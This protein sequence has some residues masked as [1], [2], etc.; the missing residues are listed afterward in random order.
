[1]W[2]TH[3]WFVGKEAN[4]AKIRNV[5]PAWA[6]VAHSAPWSA[7]LTLQQAPGP[8]CA[9]SVFLGLYRPCCCSNPWSLCCPSP[10]LRQ[11]VK[12]FWQ[13]GLYHYPLNLLNPSSGNLR[14]PLSIW[15]AQHSLHRAGPPAQKP[16]PMEKH[17]SLRR[18]SICHSAHGSSQLIITS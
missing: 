3:L 6:P 2:I 15:W 1:M 7:A 8:D 13:T 11:S 17:L 10:R 9:H 5:A 12:S 4:E 18:R 14:A 16:E